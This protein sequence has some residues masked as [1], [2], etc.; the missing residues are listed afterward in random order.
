MSRF[1][2]VAS[3]N[4]RCRGEDFRRSVVAGTYFREWSP[5]ELRRCAHDALGHL[6]SHRCGP[7]S[8][9]G[10]GTGRMCE[11]LSVTCRMSVDS[12]GCSGFLHE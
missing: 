7:G 3:R 4:L 2:L 1:R 10:L 5:S 8:V 12:S 6:A 11:R 9:P